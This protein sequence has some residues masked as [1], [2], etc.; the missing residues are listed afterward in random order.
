V[1]A[2]LALDVWVERRELERNRAAVRVKAAD[3]RVAA[4]A[5]WSRS[6]GVYLGF[7]PESPFVRVM[8]PQEVE[9]QA[10]ARHVSVDAPDDEAMA[11]DHVLAHWRIWNRRRYRIVHTE[12]FVY[13]PASVKA[14][15]HGLGR[16]AWR[17]R[18]DETL[19]LMADELGIH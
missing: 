7:P 8:K 3:E 13:G 15:R 9:E 12:F 6:S 14:A 2:L 18:V 11:V 16:K 5:R 19:G 1:T 10:G 4:W 17:A